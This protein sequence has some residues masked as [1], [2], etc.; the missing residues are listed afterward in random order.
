MI[1]ALEMERLLRRSGMVSSRDKLSGVAGIGFAPQGI[2]HAVGAGLGREIPRIGDLL[3]IP[4]K[5][6][7]VAVFVVE[8]DDMR[9]GGG[10]GRRTLKPR[11]RWGV[12]WGNRLIISRVYRG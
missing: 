4:L 3:S 6:S 2:K 11:G 7:R 12:C 8:L 9:S 1:F 5:D 10:R